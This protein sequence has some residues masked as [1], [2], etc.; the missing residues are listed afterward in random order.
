MFGD[1]ELA[2][3]NHEVL[4]FLIE[5]GMAFKSYPKDNPIR[6]A[7]EIDNGINYNIY[8]G[9]TERRNDYA[10]E[11]IKFI[12]DSKMNYVQ[13]IQEVIQIFI[14]NGFIKYYYKTEVGGG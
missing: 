6:I 14:Q 10:D 2:V 3:T 5:C 4:E 13:F 7:R 8:I 1:E 11:T 9:R 12:D